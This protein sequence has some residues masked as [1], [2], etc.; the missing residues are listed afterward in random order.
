MPVTPQLENK[1]NWYEIPY[2]DLIDSRTIFIDP[3]YGAVGSDS[4]ATAEENGAYLG[5]GFNLD[6]YISIDAIPKSEAVKL[7]IICD[8]PIPSSST[9]SLSGFSF[10]GFWSGATRPQTLNSDYFIFGA[11]A[12]NYN[13]CSQIDVTV[14]GS[15]IEPGAA[16]EPCVFWEA[17][18]YNGKGGWSGNFTLAPIP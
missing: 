6:N 11:S 18:S 15:S 7:R 10:I 14:F 13:I 16:E 3:S 1:I 4:T 17:Y 12:S 2:F 8:R 9:P 5:I